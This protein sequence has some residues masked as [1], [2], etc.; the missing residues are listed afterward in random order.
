MKNQ[1]S[2]ADG[3]LLRQKIVHLFRARIIMLLQI[4]DAKAD[5][6]QTNTICMKP[7]A[8]RR[9]HHFSLPY[10]SLHHSCQE[11]SVFCHTT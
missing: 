2:H 11:L 4:I 9:P 3:V 5:P 8:R 10:L 6:A 7:A 1:K